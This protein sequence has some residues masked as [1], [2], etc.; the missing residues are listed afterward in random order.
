MDAFRKL[1]T[2]A[3]AAVLATALSVGPVLA[4]EDDPAPA[5]AADEGG[6]IVLVEGPRDAVALVL[7]GALLAAGGLGFANARRQ[8]KG[9]RPQATGEFRWR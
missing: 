8:L 3:A 6:R 9:E 7:F 1:T 5:P 4:V 2:T